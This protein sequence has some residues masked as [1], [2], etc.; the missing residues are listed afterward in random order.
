MA[1]PEGRLI[2]AWG[3]ND[4]IEGADLKFAPPL[5][6][7]NAGGVKLGRLPMLGA[8]GRLDIIA[9]ERPPI[10]SGVRLPGPRMIVGRPELV[11]AGRFNEG[12]VR[13]GRLGVVERPPMLGP[14]MMVGRLKLVGAGRFNEGGVAMGRSGGV[15]VG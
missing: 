4:G 1:L 11:G 6:R 3:R 10:L 9:G 5:G 7:F 15:R 14:V 12:G 8:V 2:P 13:V